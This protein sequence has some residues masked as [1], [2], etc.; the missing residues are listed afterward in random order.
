[1]ASSFGSLI[2]SDLGYG[3][4]PKKSKDE[5]VVEEARNAPSA[6]EKLVVFETDLMKSHE[7]QIHSAK[8]A[9][10]SR[11]F[12]ILLTFFAFGAIFY[13]VQEEMTVVDA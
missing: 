10:L 13:S 2:S 5:I 1:M 4:A 8:E 9:K 3:Q 11:A 12:I 6:R 7:D